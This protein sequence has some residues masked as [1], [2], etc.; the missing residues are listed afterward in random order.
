MA[1]TL[2]LPV[3][4]QSELIRCAEKDVYYRERMLQA[5]RDVREHGG[6][7]WDAVY[8]A[9]RRRWR[10]RPPA[11]G[12]AHEVHRQQTLHS[13]MRAVLSRQVRREHET[14]WLP[15]GPAPSWTRVLADGLFYALTVGRRVQTPGEEFANL[16]EYSY[17]GGASRL[18]V[19]TTF[20][21]RLLQILVYSLGQRDGAWVYAVRRALRALDQ[22]LWV[23]A[24]RYRQRAP[25]LQRCRPVLCFVDRWL[26]RLLGTDADAASLSLVSFLARL[27]LVLFYFRGA[28]YD[29]AKR[30]AGVRLVHIG[31]ARQYAPRYEALGALLSL[32]L[33]GDVGLYVRRHAG[34][35][36]RQCRDAW[37]WAQH[38]L[39]PAPADKSVTGTRAVARRESSPTSRVPSRDADHHDEHATART[40]SVAPSRSPLRCVLCL[41][42]VQA[43][44]ATACGHVFCW[45]CVADWVWKQ[46]ECPLCR[47][48][49][50]LR[51]L[52]CLYHVG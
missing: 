2:R 8:R 15:L 46:R 37:Q 28:F 20:R 36:A 35:W 50:Q 33:A 38:R 24:A 34:T 22:W 41:E 11:D 17:A 7:L 3:A 1:T 12:S 21:R 30:V 31:R 51:E 6:L 52:L 47:A 19:P 49:A 10:R 27:H 48:P 43:P 42:A 39:A 13:A 25:A 14:R 45:S 9:V 23:L 32:Q 40:A 16:Y 26:V 5:L 18:I 29:V 4:Q 44:A